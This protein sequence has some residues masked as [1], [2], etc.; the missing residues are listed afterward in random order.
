MK[1][2]V[3]LRLAPIAVKMRRIYIFIA[4]AKTDGAVSGRGVASVTPLLTQAT[5]FPSGGSTV[6]G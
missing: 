1:L 5:V 3:F 2:R 6:R 4:I